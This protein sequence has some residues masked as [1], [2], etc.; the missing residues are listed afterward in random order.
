LLRTRQPI[1]AE[2]L[3]L[4]AFLDRDNITIDLLCR[5]SASKSRHNYEG[6]E[7]RTDPL[8]SGVPAWLVKLVSTGSPNRDAQIRRINLL[9]INLE[10]HYFL[11]RSPGPEDD[12]SHRKLR[13]HPVVQDWLRVRAP[14]D[15]Q[16]K[17]AMGAILLIDH[18]ID[19]SL[20]FLVLHE[21]NTALLPH[22]A[23]AVPVLTE[24]LSDP[25]LQGKPE[26]GLL[27]RAARRFG[28]LFRAHNQYE[29]AESLL[30]LVWKHQTQRLD[31]RSLGEAFAKVDSIMSS[32]AD[33]AMTGFP[34]AARGLLQSVDIHDLAPLVHSM[35]ISR[36][37]QGKNQ[38]A[39]TLSSFLFRH[40][41]S[42]PARW[43]CLC[44][45]ETLRHLSMI[46]QARW[47]RS[48]SYQY[49]RDAYAGFLSQPGR[50][51]PRS[52]FAFFG[53]LSTCS[54][55]DDPPPA[56][57][58]FSHHSSVPVDMSETAR[59]EWIFAQAGSVAEEFESFAGAQATMSRHA[60]VG[61]LGW[62][63]PESF[64]AH[65]RGLSKM[66]DTSIAAGLYSL[67]EAVPVLDEPTLRLLLAFGE[68]LCLWYRTRRDAATTGAAPPSRQWLAD[69]AKYGTRAW[70]GYNMVMPFIAP[71]AG[72]LLC[73]AYILDG[74][75]GEAKFWLKTT[76]DL[77]E[78]QGGDPR[79][80]GLQR[81]ATLL[82]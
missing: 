61:A 39:L 58:P 82:S 5:G 25:D 38:D 26:H 44:A 47:E 63:R 10:E 54:N 81:F 53:Y 69:A 78:E 6:I 46:Y 52:L 77:V 59:A 42:E 40:Q 34:P 19:D 14:R 73:D 65:A 67:D 13:M 66:L 30:G 43:R 20:Q 33:K 56:R 51:H 32:K 55:H 49:A 12:I 9:M 18:A 72:V 36:Y 60:R 27:L 70:R 28:S 41:N 23:F 24:L 3:T 2:L 17:A 48:I 68:F 8:G 62:W 64:E 16:V 7:E 50:K 71:S 15:E 37:H 80:L 74:K 45:A 29:H 79:V 4:L 31:V 1:V 22:V 35:A 57:F 11:Q 76:Q 21:S 75:L